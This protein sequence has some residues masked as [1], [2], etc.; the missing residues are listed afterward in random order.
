VFIPAVGCRPRPP[1]VVCPETD[2]SLSRTCSINIREGF[3]RLFNASKKAIEE[4][5]EGQKFAT[6][7]NFWCTVAPQLVF[8]ATAR[9]VKK[10]V[11]DDD[12]FFGLSDNRA[13]C[14]DFSNHTDLGTFLN[15][16]DCPQKSCDEVIAAGL[17][18]NLSFRDSST[19]Q[20]L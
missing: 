8:N 12:N 3:D 6:A 1:V 14:N 5:P 11:G 9:C 10:C 13:W 18:A 17:E 16:F 15:K 7:K 20:W 4:A 19:A 2:R